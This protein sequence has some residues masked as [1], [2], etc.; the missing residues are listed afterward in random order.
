MTLETSASNRL[1]RTTLVKTLDQGHEALAWKPELKTADLFRINIDQILASPNAP[2]IIEHT[3]NQQLFWS[4]HERGLSQSSDVV[5]MLNSE[6]LIRM[7]DY[8]A[9]KGTELEPIKAI[10]WLSCF[11]TT[12]ENS[13]CRRYRDLDE[14][15]QI[16]LL[17][18]KIQT[19][20]EEQLE[21]LPDHQRDR[22]IAMPCG[23]MHYEILSDDEEY[24]QFVGR[25]IDSALDMDVNYAYALLAYAA[26]SV[27]NEA[28][29]QL[30]QFR[31][32]RMQEDG[33]VSLT[34]SMECFRNIDFDALIR[35][36]RKPDQ[37]NTGLVS[38]ESGSI[39]FLD[40][41]LTD[42]HLL[43]R[44]ADLIDRLRD[45]LLTLANNL[46]TA[47]GIEAGNSRDLV[48]ILEQQRAIIS[49]GLELISGGDRKLAF[50][51]LNNESLKNIFRTGYTLVQLIRTR[52]IELLSD[53]N[54]GGVD[55][56]KDLHHKAKFGAVLL[57]LDI[58]MMPTLGFELNE[59]LKGIFNR[60][61]MCLAPQTGSSS[62]K[63]MQFR[64][65]RNLADLNEYN[66]IL[67]DALSAL[68]T[69]H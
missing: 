61:P 36:W 11:E 51:I 37:L 26:H 20:D 47:C 63:R 15:F 6:Q 30:L 48:K 53:R 68:P 19:Y 32:A 56:L 21:I 66:K 55:S 58:V 23:E 43:T 34:E 65:F 44:H 54:I 45:Q 3:P 2:K 67:A 39:N 64:P 24:V 57:H 8:D 49:L 41:V 35:K 17:Q 52:I 27:P 46:C 59:M 22:L 28:E 18:G 16:A 62:G 7:L 10:Q 25:L 69:L 1:D 60:F 29:Y 14:E 5:R 31:E 50:E 38:A 13:L 9:W 12:G 4:I 40:S 33:F 42:E